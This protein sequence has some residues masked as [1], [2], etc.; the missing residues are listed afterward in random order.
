MSGFTGSRIRSSRTVTSRVLRTTRRL[1][2]ACTGLPRQA[3]DKVKEFLDQ[4]SPTFATVSKFCLHRDIS[5]HNILVDDRD[6]SLKFTVIDFGLAVD[7]LK[8][9]Q[10]WRTESVGGDAR[11]WSPAH[12]QQIAY[13]PKHVV[14]C[15]GSVAQYTARLDHYAV[16]ILG[17]E[18][19]LGLTE[20]Q[21][22]QRWTGLAELRRAWGAYWRASMTIFQKMWRPGGFGTLRETLKQERFDSRLKHLLSD[23]Q[24]ALQA[25]ARSLQTC[26]PVSDLLMILRDLTMP[27]G[28]TWEA[29]HRAVSN[30]S[31]LAPGPS[32]SV[33]S[34]DSACTPPAHPV[35]T[36]WLASGAKTS[37]ST[38]AS[39][40]DLLS[41]PSAASSDSACT[42]P[43]P[44]VK[45][46]WLASGVKTSQRT[47]GTPIV[48]APLVPASHTSSWIRQCQVGK[49]T[50]LTTLGQTG[51]PTACVMP[52]STA[53]TSRAPTTAPRQIAPVIAPQCAA[54]SRT[55]VL[56]SG[57]GQVAPVVFSQWASTSRTPV[58]RSCQGQLYRQ[59]LNVPFGQTPQVAFRAAGAVQYVRIG[60]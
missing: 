14:A 20:H 16:G 28:M 27:V 42:P 12:W 17:L 23:V 44:L 36:F 2:M 32:P 6:G 39:S 34:S 1:F 9:R 19:L 25:M 18:M 13:G 58:L 52:S 53:R 37:R 55:P 33:T 5:A 60:T 7:P 29:V 26:K 22:A 43:A 47:T 24:R 35:K 46:L 10:D 11:Y 57:Q 56:R 8:W 30:A 3:V 38:M 4:V 45:T 15:P 50:A 48:C 40:S 21:E 49:V 59:P 31:S 51:C 54:T 41:S